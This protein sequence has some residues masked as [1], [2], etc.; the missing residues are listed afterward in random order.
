MRGEASSTS[1]SEH[2]DYG[3][4]IYIYHPN[5]KD[6]GDVIKAL[7]H[8]Y[9]HSLQD[10]TKKEENRK[11]GY[12][13][14]PYE[15]Q[16]SDAEDNWEE[17]LIYLQENINEHQE[18]K[19]SPEL[20]VD[21]II[22]VIEV[23]GDDYEWKGQTK[24]PETFAVYRVLGKGGFAKFDGARRHYDLIKLPVSKETRHRIYTIYEQDTWIY[25]EPPQAI[26]EHKESKV[27][28]ELMV[29]DEITVVNVDKSYGLK[30]YTTTTMK[31]PKHLKDYVV[32]GI[33]HR[34]LEN[35]E[36]PHVD[37]KYYII[38]PIEVYRN[39]TRNRILP[40][41]ILKL[42]EEHLYPTDTWIL[43]KGFLRG[44][45]LTEHKDKRYNQPLEDGDVIQLIHMDDPWSPIPP[46]TRGIVV[47]FEKV[48]SG[49]PKILVRWVIDAENDEFRNLPMIP[50]I[51]VWKKIEKM[52]DLI[53]VD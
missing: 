15:Q 6:V 10:P 41:N 48:P 23:E 20:E 51:D 24:R 22:M 11:L 46:L 53:V 12:E 13:G 19:V 3:N 33:K 31:T 44:E 27:N 7:L 29:G 43:R 5:M 21:D 50:E 28:P 4:M 37:T 34:Q 9:T 17:Y 16:S 52:E 38:V 40:D 26:T 49:E 35:W 45:H 32:T 36:S 1:K 42:S 14:N 30:G 2:D 39:K 18:T 47:G 25:A 8:E